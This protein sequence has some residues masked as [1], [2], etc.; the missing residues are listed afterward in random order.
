MPRARGT[1]RAWAAAVA[2]C[3][4]AC[5]LHACGTLEGVATEAG[6]AA[7][8]GTVPEAEAEASPDVAPPPPPPGCTSLIG[9]FAT[10][11]A[12]SSGGDIDASPP[13]VVI[14]F[15]ATPTGTGTTAAHAQIPVTVPNGATHT[16]LTFVAR[17]ERGTGAFDPGQGY[18]TFAA[19]TNGTMVGSQPSV[20][21][22][23]GSGEEFEINTFHAGDMAAPTKNI[24]MPKEAIPYGLTTT[25]TLDVDWSAT[26]GAVS[27]A[28]GSI[29]EGASSLDLGSAL[30]STLT[31]QL[32]GEAG[33]GSP[34][35]TIRYVS[36]CASFR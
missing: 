14:S 25:L 21:I 27:L 3:G 10:Q 18:V 4:I 28:N 2:A 11:T 16:T 35:E 19:V 23:L 13:E 29:V 33:A 32:G 15:P 31:I 5:I 6:D 30:G 20:E 34:G 26:A 17:I 24:S 12:S 22:T 36:V 9:Q 1:T 8:D 7:V